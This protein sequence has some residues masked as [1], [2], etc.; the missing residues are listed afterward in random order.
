M[1]TPTAGKLVL[2]GDVGAT[3]T[4]LGLFSFSG[5]RPKLEVMET[6]SSRSSAS[7]DDL[8]AIF[9]EKHPEPV[10][11]ACFGVPG[12]VVLGHCRTT[13]LPWNVSEYDLENNFKWDKVVLVNDL[14]ATAIAVR[15]LEEAELFELNRGR[16]DPSGTIGVVA[17]GTGLGMSIL[18][19]RDNRSYPVAS[20]GGHAS[21]APTNEKEIDL[22]K[23]LLCFT[24]SVSLER[25]AS[26]PGL[27]TIFSWLKD[28]SS[29]QEDPELAESMRRG[30]PAQVVSFGALI[31]KDPLCIEALDF[32]VSVV[33]SAAGNL[34]LTASTTG[35]IY[36]GGGI[37]PQILPKL[38]DGTFMEAF[39]NKCRFREFLINIPVYV[40][41]NDKAALIGAACSAFDLLQ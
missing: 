23:F 34:A 5:I 29:Y 41:L 12:P 33:G 20:E 17:P 14:V 37:C 8:A 2:A 1:K 35:G 7:L 18:L 38:Q 6:Y 10:S 13:N 28:S 9:L 19:R 3:K 16:Q 27:F 31:K 36:L 40:I 30:N 26:G 22:L 32:F 25:V 4:N 39:K 21:F 24:P 11:V 15:V